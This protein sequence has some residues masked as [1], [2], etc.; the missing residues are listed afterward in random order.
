MN[1]EKVKKFTVRGLL[2]LAAFF[3]L[4][5]LI[6]YGCDHSNPPVTQEAP[7]SSP[8]VRQLA[9]RACY[10]CHSNATVW[11]WYAHVAPMRWL[12]QHDVDDGRHELNFSEWDRPQKGLHEAAEAVETGEMPLWFYL[13]LH[14]EAELS[15]AEKQQLI[16]ELK[17]LAA[18][19]PAANGGHSVHDS[20]D[21]HGDTD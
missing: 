19:R 6:P 2:G 17:R 9:V 7:W 8:A 21:R 15:A 13:P 5:Q 4:I 14:A 3:L 20:R 11:P 10:D 12:V 1:T 18:S 16:A